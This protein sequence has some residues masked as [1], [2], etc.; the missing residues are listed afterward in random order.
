MGRFIRF[1]TELWALGQV[2]VVVVGSLD[3][4]WST[5]RPSHLVASD[6]WSTRRQNSSPKWKSYFPVGMC[7]VKSFSP[8]RVTFC[9][10]PP[11]CYLWNVFIFTIFGMQVAG[12]CWKWRPCTTAIRYNCNQLIGN[13]RLWSLLIKQFHNFHAYF[14]FVHV[15]TR[16]FSLRMFPRVLSLWLHK[17]MIK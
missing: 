8:S 5:R 10:L 9:W 16:F 6:G 3:G 13:C 2:W 4:D 15:S 14:Q 12:F 1:R 11:F 17:C 7:Y